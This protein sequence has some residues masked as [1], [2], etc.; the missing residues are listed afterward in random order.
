MPRPHSDDGG[1]EPEL[2]GW[3]LIQATQVLDD[4]DARLEEMC[5]D[6]ASSCRR[7]RRST[8]RFPRGRRHGRPARSRSLGEIRSW[9]EV[10]VSFPV[11]V[12]PGVDQDRRLDEITGRQLGMELAGIAVRSIDEH[13]FKPD[14]TVQGNLGQILSIAEAMKRGVD[15]GANVSRHVDLAEEELGVL[16]ILFGL[17]MIEVGSDMGSGKTGKHGH[18]VF[19]LMTE[20]NEASGLCHTDDWTRKLNIIPLSMCSAM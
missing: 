15:V 20:I 6:G 4:I 16:V 3:Q 8:N 19:D 7:R 14:D 9:T 10:G 17:V 2:P 5:M 13:A 1:E 12:P 18:P 11:S